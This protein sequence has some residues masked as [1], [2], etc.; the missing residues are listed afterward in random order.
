MS[1]QADRQG[2]ATRALL[3]WVQTE[4][5]GAAPL[6]VVNAAGFELSIGGN[7]GKVLRQEERVAS[8]QG[9]QN[10]KG[11]SFLVCYPVFLVAQ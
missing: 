7:E 5:V 10:L 11:T 4:L 2:R 1:G 9:K 3:Q 6:H 8:T